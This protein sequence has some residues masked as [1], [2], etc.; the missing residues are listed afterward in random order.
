MIIE[1][2][3]Q[4]SPEW[5]AARAGHPTASCFDKIIMP[6]TGKPSAQATNYL[7]TLA[8]ERIAGIKAETYQNDW[9]R[10]GME[11]EDEARNFFRLVKDVEVQQVGL[12]Y[13]DER[14]L[15]SCSP[16]GIMDTAG[17]EV[18]CPAIHTHVSYLLDGGLPN[19]YIPQ[20]QGAML[21]TGFQSYH[22][23]S[24]Y[25]QLPPLIVEVKRDGKFCATLKVLLEEFCA[26]LDEV[27]R[28]LRSMI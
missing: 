25:P 19:E 2:I 1:E 27:E 24:Y 8:G 20:V 10:R 22:F 14:R 9:M 23:I 17:L 21:I 18:K 15:Y 28:K 7:Y 11:M 5:F 4:R 12:I 26:E 6:K 3:E 13:P 16:D